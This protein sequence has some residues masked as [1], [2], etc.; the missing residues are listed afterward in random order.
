[1]E[2]LRIHQRSSAEMAPES[3][4]EKPSSPTSWPQPTPGHPGPWSASHAGS[5]GGLL[6][7]RGALDAA[8]GPG[9]E[10][11]AARCFLDGAQPVAH[12]AERQRGQPGSAWARAGGCERRRCGLVLSAL[13]LAG[14]GRGRG[15]RQ[16][17]G[18]PG[19]CVSPTRCLGGPRALATASSGPAP[20]SGR[21][22]TVARL[23]MFWARL[24]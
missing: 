10:L 3:S 16:G 15:D 1:M 13:L 5:M 14:S 19:P 22:L 24:A 4:I 12:L 23:R 7:S 21:Q 20:A 11:G 6:L 8:V 9:A 18:A 17:P 2:T